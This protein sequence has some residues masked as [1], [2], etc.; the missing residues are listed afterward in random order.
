MRVAKF[1]DNV[2]FG[3]NEQ[4]IYNVPTLKIR[5]WNANFVNNDQFYTGGM[6][7]V[8]TNGGIGWIDTRWTGVVYNYKN[9]MIFFITVINVI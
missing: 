3:N 9:K 5:T 4:V 8:D 6:Q 7:R 2:N 1:L